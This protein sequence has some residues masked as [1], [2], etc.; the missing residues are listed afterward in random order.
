MRSMTAKKKRKFPV[1]GGDALL[2][3]ERLRIIQPGVVMDLFGVQKGDVLL[4]VGCGPGAFVEAASGRVG[5]KGKVYAIDLQ[6][7]FIDAVNRLISER[8]LDNVKAVLSTEEHIPLPDRIADIA[9]MVTSLHEMEERK[10]LAEIHRI[11]KKEGK[12]AVVEWK[13]MRTPMGP[14][15]SE[16]LT[17]EETEL[18]LESAGFGIN[19]IF[20][21]GE[22]HYGISAVK[23]K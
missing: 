15:I 8:K 2:S 9:V 10:T 3:E 23:V 21:V 14:P 22:Y 12:V 20:E 11:L 7:P 18:I 5:N 19:R 16:R 17:E 13:K 1:D 4:D 6:E